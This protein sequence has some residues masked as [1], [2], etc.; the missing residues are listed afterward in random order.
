M[1]RHR[2]LDYH[3][4][5][6]PLTPLFFPAV[7]GVIRARVRNDRKLALLR[8]IEALRYYAAAHDGQLPRSL[9]AI[10]DLPLSLDPVTG[11]S[12]EYQLDGEMAK[13]RAPT[14]ANQTPN[15]SNSVVYEM[16]IRK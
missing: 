13:L 4:A 8:T 15:V 3:S 9:A 11:K 10:R 12:F 2:L 7:Q 1:E 16:K 6:I 14:P 5:A